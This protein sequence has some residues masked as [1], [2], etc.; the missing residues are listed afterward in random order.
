[1]K[2]SELRLIEY[3]EGS[4]KRFIIPVY[5]RNYDWKIENCKQLYDDLIQVIKNNSK[6]HFFGSIVSV[7]EPSGRNTEFL[8]IDGQQRLTT[9]SL[10]FL[11]MYNL[12]EEKIIISEDESLK[13]QIYEDFLVDKYQPQ[14]KR[15]KLKP[16]KNDQKAFSKLFNSKDDYIKDSNLTINYSYFYERI[17]K[18]EIT[19][20]ELFDAIC[21]LEIINITLNNEDNPQL[22]FESLNSTGLDLSEGDKIRNY[23]LMGLPKQKQDEY[24]EKYW[25]CIEK[26]TKYDVS[27][28]IRDYLSVK[29]LVIPSQ[30]KVYINFKKYVEDSSLKIIEI[31]EDLLSYAKRYNILLCGKTSSKELNSCINRLNRLETTVTRPFF[32][33]VLR[34]YDENQ[35]NLNEVAEAFSITESYLFRRT[36]CDLPTNALNKIFLLLNRE[37]MRYD[38]TDSNYIEK[39][40]FA[41]LSKKDRARFPNDDDFSLMFTEKP[42]YQMNSKN[43]IYI[44]ERLENFGTLEDKDIYRHYDEGEYSI[45]H[46]MPQ[47]LTPA[48]IKELGDSYEEIHDTW[49]HRIANLTLTAYNSKYSNSTFVEKKTMKNGFEDSGI[50]LNTYVSKKDKWTLAELRD[51]NDYL[52]KRA[53][54]IWAFP[55]TNYKPQEKQLDSYTLDDEASFLSGRQIAKFVYKGTEQPVVSWV[56]MYTKVLRALYLEDKT[57][58][59]KIALSTGDDLSIHFSTNKRIF[60][61]CDEIGDNV[62][63]QTNTNTQSKLSVL[64]RLYKLYGMDP[65][66]LVFYLRDSNDKE[67]EKGTRFEIR[68]RYWEYALKFIKEE[69][70]DNK[71]FDNVN[72]S[73][74]NWINGTFGIGGFA[75]CCIANYDFARVDVYFGKTNANENKI[76]FDN[77]V[78]HKL[79]I[80]SN[81]GV[82]LE[83]DRGDDVKRSIISYRLENVSIYNENDWLQ[84]AKFHAKWSKK[85]IDAIVP[86][87]K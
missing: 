52:L 53:L 46:I 5:Q 65:T 25:N 40:K 22:I 15:M 11:A 35:I 60:K 41:L 82:N 54:D 78:L 17:Q 63:V 20:D 70:F 28:F 1:M 36:I 42:I 57:I 64:N 81:L 59:A 84:I 43:K 49:L 58:I 72:T 21:R 24:Y 26:C 51:R 76:A 3:M 23:I 83:W 16:I 30:K 4:K 86:Y 10:L 8:I 69:N 32:L 62:Y 37:I 33:E 31:L 38:G 27:S 44:L 29:Q 39:L 73:K 7:Y 9:M 12:L 87:L 79:E 13:D 74:E 71:S 47:H 77:V 14:E 61:K 19:I 56:E 55:S 68:R 48:W 80:E 45:E 85:F 18:Q 2:G 50:R 75:I 6:T 66:D 67:D 34:L